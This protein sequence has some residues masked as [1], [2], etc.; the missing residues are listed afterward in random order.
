MA[1]TNYDIIVLGGGSNGLTCGAYLAKAGQKVLV[2]ERREFVGG[3]CVT[4]ELTLPGFLHNP[5]S[6]MH[7]WIHLGPVYKD[8]ELEKYGSKYVFPEV[9]YTT[10]FPDGRCLALYKDLDR[11]IE[12][13]VRFSKHDA[14]A[15]RDFCESYRGMVDGSR[16]F[17]YS[18]PS[19]PWLGWSAMM[20]TPDGAEL[21]K[22]SLS[23]TRNLVY[24]LFESPEV[25]GWILLFMNQTGTDDYPGSGVFLPP[26]LPIIH[27]TQAVGCAVG[28]SSVTAEALAK[29]IEAHD[30]TVMRNAH[31]SKMILDGERVTGVELEDGTQFT[32][33]KAVASNI[34]PK[35]TFLNMIGEENLD[36]F[37]VR[38]VDRFREDE[39]TLFTPHFAMNEAPQWKAAEFNPDV[40][41][42]WTV[43]V[44]PEAPDD[45]YKK[46]WGDIRTG[47]ASDTYLPLAI[48]PTL[49]DPSQAPEGKHTMLLWQPA[50]YELADGGAQKWHEIKEDYALKLYDWVGEFAPNMTMDN[51]L[52]MAVDSPIDI[53]ERNISMW[54]ASL[55][56]GERA[57]DQLTIFRPFYGY[58]PYRT[59]FE[60]LYMCGPSTHPE[61]G[62]SGACGY[63]AAT[64]MAEDLGIKKWWDKF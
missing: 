3:G 39:F 38:Q 23:S 33:N 11:T 40:L 34:E 49:V 56:G 35:Q 19:A 25:R 42:S 58:P 2:L 59:P 61:G 21:V 32:A 62:L 6:C 41:K 43:G 5:H 46:L 45:A 55:M 24:D 60:S 12:Q 27:Y 30:G 44:M 36:P 15:Y 63:N 64:V 47:V 10:V 28:G 29:V 57:Q 17:L 9:Q 37:F 13:I 14:E 31:V 16:T 26:L 8:L 18:P 4:E 52:K 50:V 54:K 20:E 48:I 1:D 53:E 51:I 22:T 7:V